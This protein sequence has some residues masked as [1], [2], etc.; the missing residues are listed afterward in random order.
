MMADGMIDSKQQNHTQQQQLRAR[1]M[2]LLTTERASI[3]R[4]WREA[5]DAPDT[6][7]PEAF[8][9]EAGRLLGVLVDGLARHPAA[10][11]R[12]TLAQDAMPRQEFPTT[13]RVSA[14]LALAAVLVARFPPPE[15]SLAAMFEVIQEGLAAQ[16]EALPTS[17]FTERLA[18]LSQLSVQFGRLQ[19]QDAITGLA[20]AEAPK[21]VG[22][23]SGA[24]WL[25]DADQ[26]APVMLKTAQATE[27]PPSLP[28]YLLQLFRQAGACAFGVDS[29]EDEEGW[30]PPLAGCAVAFI[31]LPDEHGCRGILT[32]HAS[33][34]R[35][36]STDDILLLSSLGYLVS[37]AL[38]NA[39]LHE[40]EHQLVNLL[41]SSIGRLVQA[42][43]SPLGQHEGF[44][45][46][47]LQVAEGLTRADAVGAYVAIDAPAVAVVTVTGMALPP[48][49]TL[50]LLRDVYGSAPG[51]LLAPDGIVSELGNADEID[52]ILRKLHYAGAPVRLGDRIAGGI[53]ALS[54]VPLNEEQTAFLHTIAGLIGVGIA[55][56]E[57][58]RSN[59]VLLVQ[60]NELL[61]YFTEVIMRQLTDHEDAAQQIMKTTAEKIAR[62]ANMPISICGWIA[63][64]GTIRIWPG[65]AVGIPAELEAKLVEKTTDHHA[66][67]PLTVN[68]RVIRA[69]VTQQVPQTVRQEGAHIRPA[70]RWLLELGVTE[71]ICVPMVVQK[72]AKG[73]ALLA[74][75][76]RH[77]LTTR[78]VALLSTYANQAA[79]ALENSLLNEGRRRT[80]ERTEKLYDYTSS[81]SANLVI[82]DI[83]KKVLQSA[84]D[85][86]R[87]QAALVTLS[88]E[89]SL[90]QRAAVTRNFARPI[91]VT[92]LFP[93]DG[94]I[95]TAARRRRPVESLDLPADGR[96]PVLR[97]LAADEGFT[98]SVTA[99][100]MAHMHGALVGTLTVFS[101][102]AR[103]FTSEE[104]DLLRTIASQAAVAIQNAQVLVQEKQRAHDLQTLV[105]QFSR[106]VPTHLVEL[107]LE[108]LEIARGE[109][110]APDALA[111][112][113][114][115]LE[116][117][118]TIQQQSC[119]ETVGQLNVKAALERLASERML[120]AAENAPRPRLRVLGAAACLPWRQAMLLGLFVHEWLLAAEA[121]APPEGLQMDVMFQ[122]AGEE[123][124]VHLDDNAAWGETPAMSPGML[125]LIQRTLQG[126]LSETRED[127]VHRVRYR[128]RATEG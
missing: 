76:A 90:Q 115:R 96:D 62:A 65:T 72:H 28:P 89:D 32:V 48:E 87:A 52:P 49:P 118:R 84:C 70:F 116:C 21:L 124:R 44:I 39:Q 67:L 35:V 78:E 1:L 86:L 121:V 74:D 29:G 125:A 58:A 107:I 120:Q 38:Q 26:Q 114:L 85:I 112:T 111:R 119:D 105:K 100:V 14:L 61:E 24:L 97:V 98:S 50:R 5:L 82:N 27:A 17:A 122:Q 83:L 47:L 11:C 101:R 36:F 22:A 64:D 9:E 104:V 6:P 45:Q 59:A 103:E 123:I 46:S 102:S 73:I 117:L 94:I 54:A 10:E 126:S 31:P 99:P 106:Q 56:M 88:V 37:A 7:P 30:P 110:A 93:D 77:P 19:D 68:N 79:L 91:A 4:A 13:S 23:E 40:K 8:A 60:M 127:G 71:W 16:A 41:Q 51:C 43:S 113:R 92:I 3:V 80:L 25:W 18:R 55:N 95:G 53:L 63:E 12:V 34:G 15:V 66:Q 42:T 33:A 128:F 69:T 109:E 20:L 2:A 81:I 57:Q 108:V 75:T